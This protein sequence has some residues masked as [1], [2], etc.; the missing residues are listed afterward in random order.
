MAG[1]GGK[2]DKCS[3]DLGMN[4]KD[5]GTGGG[6]TEGI[7]DVFQGGSSGGSTFRIRDMGPEPPH[8]AGP[9]QFSSQGRAA[10]HREES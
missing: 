8:G 10:D 1:I 9:G 6:R 5:T 4:D 7:W 3:E 2:I